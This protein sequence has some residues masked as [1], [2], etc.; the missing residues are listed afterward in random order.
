MTHSIGQLIELFEEY[1]KNT[2][3]IEKAKEYLF[4]KYDLFLINESINALSDNSKAKTLLDFARKVGFDIDIGDRVDVVIN[5]LNK[6]AE[7]LN[8]YEVEFYEYVSDSNNTN[9]L[10][11]TYYSLYLNLVYG[12]VKHLRDANAISLLSFVAGVLGMPIYIYLTTGIVLPHVKELSG[13]LL[14]IS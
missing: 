12:S 11:T 4:D 9:F 6:L 8:K 2:I 5:A 7:G 14:R 1:Y 10:I 13:I 3:G